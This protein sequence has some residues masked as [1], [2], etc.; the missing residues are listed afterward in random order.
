MNMKICIRR[1]WS[2]KEEWH[3]AKVMFGFAVKAK[4]VHTKFFAMVLE[5]VKKEHDLDYGEIYLCPVC[6]P[7]EFSKLAEKCPVCNSPESKFVTI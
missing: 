3:K 6:G 4:E 1:C 2:T 7:I 5:S